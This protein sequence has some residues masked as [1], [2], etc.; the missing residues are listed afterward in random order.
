MQR[1]FASFKHILFPDTGCAAT[2][3]M[4]NCLILNSIYI[5]QSNTISLSRSKKARQFV[6]FF[7][8]V[9]INNYSNT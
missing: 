5:L 2:G 3:N 6:L 8:F 1:K 7:L 9:V 4:F